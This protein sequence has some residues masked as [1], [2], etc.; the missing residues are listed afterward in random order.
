MKLWIDDI[1]PAPDGYI[2]CKSVNETIA[3][4]E[5]NSDISLID[6]DHD[7]GD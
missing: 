1:R 2:W 4:I 5:N 6:I 3:I 7:A